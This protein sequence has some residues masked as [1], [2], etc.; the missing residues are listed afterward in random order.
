MSTGDYFFYISPGDKISKKFVEECMQV[1]MSKKVSL[2][3]CNTELRN[4]KKN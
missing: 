3:M 4:E 1:H 2:V